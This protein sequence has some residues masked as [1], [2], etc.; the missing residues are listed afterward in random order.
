MLKDNGRNGTMSRSPQISCSQHRWE[1][2]MW[3][4][5]ILGG[6]GFLEAE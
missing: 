2:I 1:L 3:E 6:P 5:K 4:V